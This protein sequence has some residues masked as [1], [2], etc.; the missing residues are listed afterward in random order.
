MGVSENIN[1]AAKKYSPTVTERVM[2]GVG[3]VKGWMEK[4]PMNQPQKPRREKREKRERREPREGK[5]DHRDR[6]VHK[7][8][9]YEDGKIK[10]VL[11]LGTHE[12][13][14]RAPKARKQPMQRRIARG[15]G[16]ALGDVGKGFTMQDFIPS[17][18]GLGQRMG[19][20]DMSYGKPHRKGKRRNAEPDWTDPYYIPPHLKQFF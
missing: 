13:K 9:K 14:P 10:E 2:S 8:E 18:M 7:I 19:F 12:P 15:V 6:G 5:E 4:H 17:N 20:E 11:Y 16:G 3:A 1:T